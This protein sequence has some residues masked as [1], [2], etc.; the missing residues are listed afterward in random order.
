MSFGF[1]PSD[2]L[3]GLQLTKWIYD[4]CFDKLN[5][6]GLTRLSLVTTSSFRD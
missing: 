3:A 1:A 2:I 4:N 6:S 5:T